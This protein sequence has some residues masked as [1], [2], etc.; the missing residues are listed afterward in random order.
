MTTTRNRPGDGP[1]TAHET[2][3][4]ADTN[5]TPSGHP[6]TTDTRPRCVRC[7]HPLTV[8]R[9]VARAYGPQCW[10]RTTRAQLDA[11]RDSVG[12]R[13]R[14]LAA[15]VARADTDTLALLSAALDDALDALDAEGVAR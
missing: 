14:T 1:R 8:V 12:R 7:G 4:T 11:R 9:S 10:T 2:A 3:W 5:G 15:L 6:S 13:L